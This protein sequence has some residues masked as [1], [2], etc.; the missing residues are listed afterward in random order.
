MELFRDDKVYW[1]K[2]TY[3]ERHVPKKAGFKWH[4]DYCHNNCPACKADLGR[5]WWTTDA[6]VAYK[7]A[8][9]ADDH[10]RA[11]LERIEHERM[12][13]LAAS[14]AVD[15]EM[16]IPC[17]VGLAYLPYQ[18]AGIAFAVRR[19]N[20]LISDEM[21][22]GKTVEAIGVVNADPSIKK[23]LVVCPASLK[24][25]WKRELERWLVRKL[26]V[27]IG[28][29][30]RFP[31]Q[32]DIIVVNYD[33]LHRHEK[34]VAE[35]QWDLLIVDEAHYCKNRKARRSKQVFKIRAQRNLLLTGTPIVNR[36]VE[37]WPLLNFLDPDHWNNFNAYAKR[38]CDAHKNRYGWDF[39]GASHL[40]ELQEKLRATLMVR[41]L[42]QDVLIDLPAKRRQVIELSTNGNVGVIEAEA[43]AWSK[44]QAHLA[45]LRTQV[46]LAKANDDEA[47]YRASVE[48]LREG[49]RSSF[50][51]MA[52]RRHAVALAKVP[53][54]VEQLRLVLDD[55]DQK[56]V[57]FAHHHDVIAA[58][59][60][61]FGNASVTL[62]GKTGLAQRHEAVERFQNDPEVR[63]F[64]GS[65]TA[66]GVGL[67]LTAASHVV[68]AE[69]DWVPGN[70]TQAED[71]CHRIGQRESVLVQHLVFDGS[72]DARM[73]RTLVEK[74]EVLD[75]TL[76][77][78]SRLECQ[79]P[80]L[81]V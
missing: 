58:I 51:E 74:Q 81:P 78:R 47:E 56:V 32:A 11:D 35:L 72:L 16:A 17:P 24:L 66:A 61:A 5:V 26:S 2:S 13:T 55:S 30:K 29:S 50:V 42:K 53:L 73:A 79:E 1:C 7:L 41:R 4:G 6:S 48:R 75:A 70:M 45:A 37:L 3:D 63:L 40:A 21:G 64:I 31:A 14:K 15:A 62:T 76:D 9:Y 38:Y 19:D 12:E 18:R 52:S 43:R 8:E 77:E 22:L 60:R 44:H 25:N 34:Q 10:V 69:L 68:F 46:E 80:L 54:V 36:P 49:A 67:T 23:V 27:Q 20:T 28:D 39:S 57:L 59:A 33:V 65:I 71:R